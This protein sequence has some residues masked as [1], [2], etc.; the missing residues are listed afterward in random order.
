LQ[1][2]RPNRLQITE[3]QVQPGA[4][5]RTVLYVEDNLANLKLVERLIAR[6]PDMRLLSAKDGM[7]RDI[8]K[9]IQ[10][11]FSGISPNQ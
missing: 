11:G 9:G 5:L 1:L 3:A 7:P 8:E 2:I 10:A 6:R 4:L